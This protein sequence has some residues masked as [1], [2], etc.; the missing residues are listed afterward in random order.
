MEER[1]FYRNVYMAKGEG[2]RT[3][4]AEVA[5]LLISVSKPYRVRNSYLSI[6]HSCDAV[7]LSITPVRLLTKALHGKRR[8]RRKGLR[9][10]QTI[11]K[12]K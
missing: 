11:N 12:K 7:N 6:T 8:H 5:R 10:K 2:Y 4:T 3:G 1:S 9:R